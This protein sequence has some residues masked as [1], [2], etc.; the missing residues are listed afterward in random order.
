MCVSADFKIDNFLI[1]Q[2]T[3][4]HLKSVTFPKIYLVMIGYNN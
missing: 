4:P 3:P 2:Q 1:L